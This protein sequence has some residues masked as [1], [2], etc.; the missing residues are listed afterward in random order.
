MKVLE[1]A[2]DTREESDYLPHNYDKNCVVY[3]GTHDNDTVI[4]WL[5]TLT[6][7]DKAF[8]KR[9]LKLTKKEGYNWGMIRGAWS[10]VGNLAIAQMQDFIGYDSRA[11]INIPSTIGQNWKWRL[12]KG[13]LD[14]DL[15]NKIYAI[16]KTYGR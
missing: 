4:G 3:T 9:Y 13:Q 5:N 16:T 12:I 7:H 10:S 2:F 1:F 8:C 15:A 11:R 14:D 6:K